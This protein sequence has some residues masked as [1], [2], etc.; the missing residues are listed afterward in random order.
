M[1]GEENMPTWIKE[2]RPTLALALP[3]MLGQVS[4]MLMGILDSIMVGRVGAVPLAGAAFAGAVFTVF[5]VGCIGLLQPG[6]VLVAREHGAGRDDLCGLWLRH[7]RRLAWVAGAGLG[8]L[9][10]GLLVAKDHFGQPAEVV[11]VMGPYFALIAVSLVPTLLFQVDR[12]FAEALG[13]AWAPLVIMLG[14]VALNAVLNWIFIYGKLGFPA[15]GLTGAGLATL[16]A[17]VVSVL[18]LRA[19]L[20]RVGEFRVAMAEARRAGV[21]AGRMRELLALGLPMGAA[22][23][24]ETAAFSAAAVMAG[25]LGTVSL[26]AHQIV[27]SCAALTF[28][29]PLGVALAL[30][31]RVGKAVGAGRRAA[32]RPIALGAT[33]FVVAAAAVTTLGYIVWGGRIAA[34]FVADLAVV[35]LAGRV[36]VVVV[37][38][39]LFDGLQVVFAGALRGLTD[40]RVPTL[41]AFGAYWGVALPLGYFWGVRGGGG[42]LAIWVALAAG[43]ALAA[44]LLGARLRWM[45]R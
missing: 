9:M 29:V 36:F 23:F 7:A 31:V 27:I 11:A 20:G 22:L 26:A 40:V 28:M 21:E 44:I 15:W 19:W 18:V 30:G 12:Q 2:L 5:F 1:I 39:Q 14:S 32:V 3:I 42:L 13:R 38:F 10:L 35:A 17:R 4:Q 45:T 24:F 41:V 16:V 43:L 33:L 34:L 37:F 6:A 25:W 8:A